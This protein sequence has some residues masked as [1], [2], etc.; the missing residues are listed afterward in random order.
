MKRISTS[1]ALVLVH[2]IVD[3]QSISLLSLLG[4]SKKVEIG[5]T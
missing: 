2:C 4:V 3:L 1:R 5:A